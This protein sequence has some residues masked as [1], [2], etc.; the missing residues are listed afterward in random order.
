[1]L[2][3]RRRRRRRSSKTHVDAPVIILDA[4]GDSAQSNHKKL[5]DTPI[6]TS[7]HRP[8]IPLPPIHTFLPHTAPPPLPPIHTFLP[9]H[10]LPPIAAP[11]QTSI[12]VY[13][14]SFESSISPS[15][16]TFS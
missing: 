14:S 4:G 15:R 10:A 13:G 1:M 8:M 16:S 7:N 6:P 9:N 5:I 11:T 3:G 12:A 2:R